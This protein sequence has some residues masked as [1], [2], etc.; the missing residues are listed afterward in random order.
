[1]PCLR[2]VDRRWLNGHTSV[3]L[4]PPLLPIIIAIINAIIGL[5]REVFPMIVVK[6]I[7]CVATENLL[8]QA[9][10]HPQDLRAFV[11]LL[12]PVSWQK[13]AARQAFTTILRTSQLRLSLSLSLSFMF[14]SPLDNSISTSAF[15]ISLFLLRASP[16][17]G[18][19]KV[20]YK[21]TV[22]VQRSLD[23]RRYGR[24]TS[25]SFLWHKALCDSH[26]FAGSPLATWSY[27]SYTCSCFVA[28]KEPLMA[29]AF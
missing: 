20:T 19:Q 23:Q 16:L 12:V 27:Q 5:G 22:L 4:L 11:V 28:L 17:K 8:W 1:M 3:S 15:A 29:K 24:S 26:V 21:Y 9:E 6:I 25:S 2:F 18:N 13:D 7:V 10:H 14:P